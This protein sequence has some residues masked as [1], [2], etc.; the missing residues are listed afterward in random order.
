[1]LVIPATRSFF[2]QYLNL[3]RLSPAAQRQSS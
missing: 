3:S 2:K 1:M